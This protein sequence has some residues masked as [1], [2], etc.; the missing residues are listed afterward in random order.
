MTYRVSIKDLEIR[1][2]HLNEATGMPAAPYTKGKD[3][4]FHCNIGNYHLSQAYGGV[5][6]HQMSNENGGVREPIWSGHVPKREALERLSAF[7]RG[8]DTKQKTS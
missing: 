4:K 6:V 8:M 7:I 2:A 3:D 1:V 5:C